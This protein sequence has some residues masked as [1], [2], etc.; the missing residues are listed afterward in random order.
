MGV[1]KPKFRTCGSNNFTNKN[2][3]FWQFSD[4]PKM[5]EKATALC[6]NGNDCD[7]YSTIHILASVMTSNKTVLFFSQIASSSVINKIH[8]KLHHEDNISSPSVSPMHVDICA[9]RSSLTHLQINKHHS[10]TVHKLWNIQKTNQ[11]ESDSGLLQQQHQPYLTLI[12]YLRCGQALTPA[13]RWGRISSA[14]WASPNVTTR[15]QVMAIK[16]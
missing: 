15:L 7:Y 12:P 14:Q 8:C 5:G 6:R 10:P 9:S 3:I 1:S 13:Q 4:S 11:S 16:P 2:K